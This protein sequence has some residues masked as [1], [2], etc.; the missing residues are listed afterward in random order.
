MLHSK[1]KTV[2]VAL[3]LTLF[4]TGVNAQQSRDRKMLS[5]EKIAEQ[6]TDK[7]DKELNL[8]DE[9]ESKI[10]A[11][12]LKYAQQ[13]LEQR[14]AMKQQREE[15]CEEE[16]KT[17]PDRK[18][19]QQKMDEQQQAQTSEVMAVLDDEQKVKYTDM[20]SKQKGNSKEPKGKKK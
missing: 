8:T 18:E 10:Y 19:M 16:T 5:P 2:L 12:N 7:M 9:Q 6:R 17:R 14:E 4:A 11:I 20:L 1:F 15:G 13:N 3:V